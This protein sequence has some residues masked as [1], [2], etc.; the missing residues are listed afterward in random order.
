[1][2]SSFIYKKELNLKGVSA[3][4]KNNEIKLFKYFEFREIKK[5]SI[6]VKDGIT[7]RESIDYFINLLYD[8]DYEASSADGSR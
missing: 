2:K 8:S 4:P 7:V 1:M 6:V 5:A 3:I